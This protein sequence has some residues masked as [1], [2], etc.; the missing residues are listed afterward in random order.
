MNDSVK[1]ATTK[2][3]P[4]Q[5]NLSPDQGMRPRSAFSVP[6]AWS[7]FMTLHNILG[8]QAIRRLYKAGRLQAALKIGKPDD[9]YEQ[10]AD[11]VADQ[12]MRMT[13]AVKEP[14]H[15]AP[16][17]AI[18]KEGNKTT[19]ADPEKEKPID[20]KLP[21]FLRQKAAEPSSMPDASPLFASGHIVSSLGAGHP[22]DRTTRNF[23]EPRFRTDFSQVRVHTGQEAAESASAINARAYTLKSNVVFGT[24]EYQPGTAQGKRLLAHELAHVAQQGAASIEPYVIQR[25]NFV[26]WPG[27]IG[28]D[29]PGTRQTKGDIISE[30]VQRTGDPTYA[31]LGPMLLEFNTRTCELTVRKE[32]N[33]VRAG[34]GGN[35]LSKQAFDV[36][37]AR[38]LRIAQEKLNGWVTIRVAR[39]SGCPLSCSGGMI[40]VNVVT[41]EG[42]GSYS[43]TLK[44]HPAYGREDAANI[45]ADASDYTIWH[46][47]G[48]LSLGAADEYAESRRPD[49]TARP[50]SRVNTSDWSV[51]SCEANARRAIMHARHFSHLPAWL[52]RRFPQCTFTLNEV[53][54]PIVVEFTPFLS[55]GGFVSSAGGGLYYS[56]GFDLGIPLDRLRRLELILG[57]RVNFIMDSNAMMALL[58]GFRAGLEGQF[59]STGFR[60][61]AFAEG[62]G[63][64]FTNLSTGEFGASPYVEGGV[65][66]GYSFSGTFNIGVEGA[67]GRR[68]SN[69]VD[70]LSREISTEF[71]P[72]F[73]LGLSLSASF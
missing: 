42:T 70:P 62:G 56:A 18:Q 22:L 67:G 4:A 26:P 60:L 15:R 71:L 16:T 10:E 25:Q 35:Q 30:Q 39:S 19:A 73:R 32:I 14:V 13:D 57:P 64:G 54:R 65:G 51:M 44:L 58:L 69:I 49:G 17:P 61:G 55:P 7:D 53:D 72:Y 34:T 20:P 40:S 36:L 59:G 8:N 45:G 37:K 5:A 28:H 27:Q 66:F 9:E 41:T 12:V 1:T 48:H 38:I 31:P 11:R 46:E 2:P 43:S 52:G 24:G 33:F 29:V 63:V 3:E 68:T 6:S 23:F 50:E 21:P 47:L